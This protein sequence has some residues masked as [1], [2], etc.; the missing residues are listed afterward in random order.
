MNPE[1]PL[2]VPVF[3]LLVPSGL[4]PLGRLWNL[5]EVESYERKCATGAGLEVSRLAPL[6][7][8]FVLL[9]VDAL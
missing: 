3:E 4:C 9:T 7:V 5:Q 8:P 6:S 1:C 2:Q